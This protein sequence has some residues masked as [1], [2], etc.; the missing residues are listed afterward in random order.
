MSQP[1]LDN[2]GRKSGSK[3]LDVVSKEESF[4]EAV[5]FA[6]AVARMKGLKSISP[7]LLAAGAYFAYQ[8]GHL[9][10]RPSV[11]AHLAAN[12][13][14][15]KTLIQTH[16]WMLGKVPTDDINL[17]L[18]PSIDNA[19]KTGD[20]DSDPLIV[21][22][23]V[24]IQRSSKELSKRR[25]AYH[26]AGHA[27]ISKALRPDFGI[28]QM[29]IVEDGETDGC[30]SF[31]TSSPSFQAFWTTPT[32]EG[33]LDALCS[34]LA[35]RVAEQRKYGHNALDAGAASDLSLATEM[36]WDAITK[37]GLD[38]EFGP[39]SLPTLSRLAATSSGWLFD[40]AQR[41]LQEILKEG[42]E[43]TETLVRE[44]WSAIE[45]VATALFEKKTLMEDEIVSIIQA[46]AY[47]KGA[48]K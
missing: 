32:R 9:S 17:P 20:D 11:C 16:G 44:R 47:G 24:G 13:L 48:P 28:T 19:L 27:V 41:R 10:K 5:R 4:S 35:G 21:I 40:E 23:N 25:T 14:R 45:A 22:L 29:T 12:E 31:D 3:K 46:N 33:F 26:E 42:I 30:T 15:L 43:R 37:Y 18:A 1:I 7:E 8:K 6:S 2:S 39:V 38:F 34:L 36:V